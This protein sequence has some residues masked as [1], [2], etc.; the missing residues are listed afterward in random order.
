VRSTLGRGRCDAIMSVPATAEGMT[1]TS[2]YYEA[3]W[4]FVSPADRA[5]HVRSFDD[6]IL[7]R[8]RVGVPVVGEGY[9]TPP[10]AALGRRGIARNLRLYGISGLGSEKIVAAQ[11]IDDLVAGKI[12]L[13]IL[14]GPSAGYYAAAAPGAVAIEPTPASDGPDVPMTVPIAIGVS[15]GNTELR[16]LLNTILAEK[17]EEIDKILASYHLP[18]TG[19]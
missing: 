10:L 5:V 8:I 1:T 16:D 6:P 18:A 3:G 14:W 12:D 7:R 19:E 2:P 11:M 4:V 15:R 13:A 17:K 9:D